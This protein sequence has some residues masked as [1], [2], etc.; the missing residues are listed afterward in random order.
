MHGLAAVKNSLLTC[1]GVLLLLLAATP[2]WSTGFP[3]FTRADA[4]TV[5]RGGTV[6]VLDSGAT[7]VLA[8]DFDIERD[9]MTAELRRDVKHGTLTLNDDGTFVYRHNGNSK[10]EDRFDYRAFDGTRYS[11][12]TRVTIRIVPGDPIAPVIV[13][14]ADIAVPEDESV[15]ITL[16]DLDV[17]DPDSRYPA[18]FTLTVEDGEDYQRE[19]AIIIPDPDYNGLLSV[20]VRVNDGSSDSNTFAMTI[21]VEPVN[22]A[23]YV[24]GEVADQIAQETVPFEVGLAG[25]FADIDSVELSYGASGL[26]ASG[27]LAIDAATGVLAG[28]PI[29]VDAQEEPYRVVI[30][31]T[32]ESGATA[33]LE[34]NLTIVPKDRAD[35]ALSLKVTPQPAQVGE[36][37]QWELLVE[38]LGPADLEEGLLQVDWVSSG[39]PLELATDTSCTLLNNGTAAPGVECVVT[40]LAA[41]SSISFVLE[42]AQDAAGDSTAI[43]M[44]TAEDPDT[45]N[46][47]VSDSLNVAAGFAEGAAQTLSTASQDVVAGDID[48]DGFPDLAAISTDAQVFWNTGDRS[49]AEDATV[50]DSG[51]NPGAI[52]LL[53]WNMDGALDVAIGSGGDGPSVIYLNDGSRGFTAGPTLSA[54]EALWVAGA[55]VSDL[56]NDG[57]A[58]W[59]LSGANG[60]VVVRNDGQGSALVSLVTV[61]PGR[62]VAA[63]DFNQ[64]GFTDLAVTAAADR[65][66]EIYLQD[67]GSGSFNGSAVL[68]EGSVAS[69]TAADINGDGLADLLLAVDGEALAVPVSRVLTGDGLGGF[70]LLDELGASPTQRLLVGDVDADGAADIVAV[71]PTGVHQVFAGQPGAGYVL[72]QE[73]IISNGMRAGVLV[74]INA[75]QSLDLILAG[76]VSGLVEIHF[77]DGLGSLGPGDIT[78]PVIS[79]MGA[80]TV[81][82]DAGDSYADAGATALDDVDGDLTEQMN[83]DNPVNTAIVGTYLVTYS[84]ADRA[85]NLS[86]LQRTVKVTAVTGTGGG[87]G[88]VWGWLGALVL[89]GL[90]VLRRRRS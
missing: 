7:S 3:P 4:A 26:P 37:V 59:V 5:S 55:T 70:N 56:D 38:N 35:L 71:K 27:S 14:Q 25:F 1:Y 87:G 20:P 76:E 40:N 16:A 32:D 10:E 6:S 30:T 21:V 13:G 73:Q 77:N 9:P 89:A 8:N 63:A 83:V 22:D 75:D 15:E 12:D 86:E 11:S 2:A 24:V 85:G 42:S 45:S 53:D 44:V 84:V 80:A 88:G 65:A 39:P 90:A 18:D 31:A 33:V 68:Q 51:T 46:N 60:T 67:G 62:D 50:L 23:P 41:D 17:E 57:V 72:Q 47:M 49:L 61:A 82:L 79:L 34:F 58:E 81:T 19:G 43:A 48:N 64:D 69:A 66:V 52:S 74:D 36:T 54:P 29:Q 78:P 28:T